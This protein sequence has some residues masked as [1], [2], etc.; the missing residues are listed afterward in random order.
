[1]VKTI[2]GPFLWAGEQQKQPIAQVEAELGIVEPAAVQ[3][4]QGVLD[5]AGEHLVDRRDDQLGLV[6][7][8]V[9]AAPRAGGGETDEVSLPGPPGAGDRFAGISLVELAVNASRQDHQRQVP[10]G[11]STRTDLGG[12]LLER[13]ALVSVCPTKSRLREVRFDRRLRR[14]WVVGDASKTGD[15]GAHD[16]KEGECSAEGGRGARRAEP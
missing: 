15:E 8:D 14:G 6:E 13:R 10:Q 2:L 11:V 3:Q 16:P 12:A 1:M 4:D 7:L 9:V 5:V